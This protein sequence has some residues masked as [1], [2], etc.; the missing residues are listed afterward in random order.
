MIKMPR[1]TEHR[2]E[3][4]ATLVFRTIERSLR[5]ILEAIAVS[6]RWQRNGPSII[7]CVPRVNP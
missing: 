4:Y 1:S 5:T 3:A 6:P 2:L 7:G